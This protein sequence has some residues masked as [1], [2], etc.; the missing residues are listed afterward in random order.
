MGVPAYVTAGNAV[1]SIGR[2]RCIGNGWDLTVVKL[3]L[4]NSSLVPSSA[5]TLQISSTSD[6]LPLTAM[7]LTDEQEAT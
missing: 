7:D 6:A 5:T 1:S 3:F 4:Q 2:L